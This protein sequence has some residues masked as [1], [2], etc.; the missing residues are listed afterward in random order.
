LTLRCFINSTAGKLLVCA[1]QKKP[2]GGFATGIPCVLVF[3]WSTGQQV[4][5][6]PMGSDQDGFAYDAQFHPAGFVMA[7]S[8]AFP[9][10]GHVGRRA[11]ILHQQQDYKR[12][13]DQTAS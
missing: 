6:M 2:G 4:R 10:K 1:G 7:A 9:G 3:D 13:H 11:T 5:E 8:C 12:P